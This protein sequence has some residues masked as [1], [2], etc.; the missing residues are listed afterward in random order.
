[1]SA[2]SRLWKS[3]TDQAEAWSPG[4]EREAR[5]LTDI[6][7]AISESGEASISR[8]AGPTHFTASMF[9]FDAQLT[10]VVLCYHRKG[11]FWVQPG[12]H[13]EQDDDSVVSAALRELSEETGLRADDVLV[14][15]VADIDSHGL[16]S[17]FGRC[18]RHLDFGVAA[19]VRQGQLP[20]L[21]VSDESE[22]LG[23]WPVAGLPPNCPP[24]FEQRLTRIRARLFAG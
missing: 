1:M 14:W 12:G 17:R 7:K 21:V 24:G 10:H 9:V 4:N 8:D 19:V 16:N 11:Q 23:W 22:E 13:A 20:Q 2:R 18:K 6:R 5:A 15:G 3:I